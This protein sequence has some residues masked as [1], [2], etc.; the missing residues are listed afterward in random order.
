MKTITRQKKKKVI[1]FLIV[2]SIAD[3]K[4]SKKLLTKKFKYA[5]LIKQLK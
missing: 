2:A 3:G 1:S 4:S 5:I